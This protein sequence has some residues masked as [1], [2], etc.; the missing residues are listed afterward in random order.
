MRILEL[1]FEDESHNWKL[2]STGFEMLTLLV[3]ASGVGKT[4][5]LNSILKIKKISEGYSLNGIKWKI[6]FQVPNI[7]NTV[8][9]EG[10]FENKGY[11]GF[12]AENDEEIGHDAEFY[13]KIISERIR[14]GDKVLVHRSG[15]SI[16]YD[17]KKIVRL[18]RHQ[19][20]L[21]LLR[22]EMSISLIQSEFKRIE[23]SD[24]SGATA[25]SSRYRII[26]FENVSRE[27]NT[28]KKIQDSSY[29]I[30]EKL[31]ACFKNEPQV[32]NEIED[33]FREIFPQVERIKFEKIGKKVFE[34]INPRM[35]FFLR[36][37]PILQ[38]K[39]KGVKQWIEYFYLSSG[40]LRSLLHLSQIYL[41]KEGS[42][43][44][45]DEFENSLGINCLDEITDEI[46]N[47]NRK[48]QFIVTSHHPY[49]INKIDFKHWKIVTRKKGVIKTQNA[50]DLKLGK[51]K[52]EAFLQLLQLESYNPNL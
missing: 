22:K 45:I 8:L 38:I 20:I 6:M 42:V 48:L 13:P 4:Q 30:Q 43:F 24:Q 47:P 9:W 14:I 35:P 37:I 1:S 44:L 12:F 28:L 31:Y 7:R 36:D 25:V 17:N 51:S 52:H 41:C 32:F 39:E 34:D 10:E 49:I 15:E 23:F 26:E 18:P 50:T 2:S 29:G 27:L 33:R 16:K 40:M 21:F 11:I 46:M 5:I 3:G 19:S